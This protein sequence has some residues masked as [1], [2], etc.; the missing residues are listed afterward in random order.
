MT[1]P[2]LNFQKAYALLNPD[3][4][5]AVDEIDGP[6]MVIAGPG[7]GKTQVLT[8]RIANIL[9]L[10]DTNPRSILALTYT[11]SAATNMRERLVKMIGKDGHYVQ[12]A[13]F[14]AFCS[15]VI[16]DHSEYF[17][18]NGD[19]QP[20]N[21][22]ERY[23]F[24]REIIDQLDL[25]I[26]K[27]VNDPYHNLR[28][29]S[30][31][32]SELKRENIAVDKFLEIIRA[33]KDALDS[34]ELKAGAKKA[35]EKK[36]AKNSELAKIYHQY[37]AVLVQK[38]RYDFE[39]MIRFVIEAFS[40]NDDLLLEYQENL[41]YFLIDEYQD[42]NSAQN[43]IIDLL[44]SYW[45]EKP[46]VFVVGDPN[47]SIFRF[48]G[49]S[50][51]NALAFSDKYP[52]A[53]II[54]LTKGYR[55]PQPIY[56]LAHQLIT[57][58]NLANI[59]ELTPNLNQTRLA[60][61]SELNK[62]LVGRPVDQIVVQLNILPSRTAEIIYLA[63]QIAAL[64]KAKVKLQEIA[65][66]YHDNADAELIKEVL[67]KWSLPFNVQSSNDVLMNEQ[68]KQ[69][70]ELFR[71]ID[72]IASDDRE[73][74]VFTVL[75][76][77]WLGLNQLHLMKL[78]K[79]ASL[80]QLSLIEVL[81]QGYLQVA[82]ACQKYSL[83]ESDFAALVEKINLLRKWK[84]E[85]AN[86]TFTAWFELVINQSGFLDYIKK[87][88][89]HLEV[90]TYLKTLFDQIKNLNQ[91]DKA[92]N[93]SAFIKALDLM[94]S[95]HLAIKSEQIKL[96]GEAI[97]LSTVHKA[98]GQEWNYVFVVGLEDKK[99]GN[100]RK[101]NN[102]DLPQGVL[103]NTNLEKKDRDEDDRRL[104]YVALT[105]ASQKLF[106]SAA[107]T[108]VSG[109]QEK[110]KSPSIFL[111]EINNSQLLS[112]DDNLEVK[113]ELLSKLVE[114]P[115][116]VQDH[117]EEIRTFFCE[118][119]KNYQL[120]VSGLRTYLHDQKEFVEKIL[121]RIPSA[122]APFFAYGTAV[123]G[124]L[125]FLYSK[126]RELGHFPELPDVL[127]SY[128]YHLS[129]EILTSSEFSR[130]LKIGNEVLAA[131]YREN[132]SRTYD[133]LA[134]EKKLGG[135]AQPIIIADN[136]SIAGRIDRL[137]WVDQKNR[138]IKVIDYKTGK[139]KSEN[140][141]EGKVGTK[142]YSERELNLPENIRGHY[143][144][145]LLFYKL[146]IENDRSLNLKVS[147]GVF[148]FVEPK[149]NGK[150]VSRVFELK[151]E[152]VAELKKL[153]IQVMTEIHNLEFLQHLK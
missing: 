38:Q 115:A 29:I 6:V 127:A 33:E 1:T 36:L 43:Q 151:D 141:I 26:L 102:I 75:S 62:N 41:H 136:I 60:I 104:F 108:Y 32:V 89:N 42:T 18:I 121:L 74:D 4:K 103:K 9:Q 7:T 78:A 24:F 76:F 147:H 86:L 34:Q 109:N 138:L 47:Q 106:L 12:I 116:L 79:I 139:Q 113:E 40:T 111:S 81:D 69:L 8:T 21:D 105:R 90:I 119:V 25:E 88:P 51:E 99:W 48:Q 120:T 65:I 126:Q 124:A 28:D 112:T 96:T 152:D 20:L 63:E 131:Y 122:K 150:L 57:Q 153:V 72:Q 52:E 55:C 130:R 10:T 84:A 117:D 5:Q 87:L 107:K 67:S 56:D 146:L 50:V 53:K 100:R 17:P 45:S 68:I 13:T 44:A 73:L 82:T 132:A 27:P 3:Q 16:A 142:D 114:Q 94:S 66:L 37:Q 54:T 148:E 58:N 85:D 137:D 134:L 144:R 135:F 46:N 83:S 15:E 77:K 49:A 35:L 123:H 80:N 64:R 31:R 140:E 93:L 98:K 61:L 22:L 129:K 133:I 70:L 95:Y 71:L 91:T 128:R 149:E 39:D 143:K 97:H 19:A 118:V 145:Q 23:E 11:E 59:D 30:S 125:E 101:R 2:S 92:L 14:H 110:S